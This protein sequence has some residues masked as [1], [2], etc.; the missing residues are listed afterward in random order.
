MEPHSL[1]WRIGPPVV[2]PATRS[3]LNNDG[4]TLAH[5]AV[6]A[7]DDML[8]DAQASRSLGVATMNAL[9]VPLIDWVDGDPMDSIGSGVSVVA[10]VG[11][12]EPALRKFGAKDVRVIEREPLDPDAINAPDS[13]DV[14][15]HLPEAV[16]SAFAGVDVLFISG[17]TMGY[18]GL[19]SYLT[20]ATNI[21]TVIVIG[22]SASFIPGPL[23]DTGVSMVAGA[24]VSAP[25]TVRSGILAG[26]CAA[27]LHQFGL[28][29]VFV[30]ATEDLQGIGVET[31]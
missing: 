2:F 18:G 21:P 3:L 20:A 23:F 15:T 14:S 28:E 19:D 13:I 31:T 30:T 29:K 16:D 27:D 6:E 9:S 11:L 17:S 1:V 7:P 12:F 24:R 5:W 4:F 10:I 8:F 26:G 25:D 22:A